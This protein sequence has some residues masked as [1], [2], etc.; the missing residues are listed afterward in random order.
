MIVCEE[1]QKLRKMLEKKELSGM[2]IQKLCLKIKSGLCG[3][4]EHT[5]NI[6]GFN[7]L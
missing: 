1:M 5:L 6:K 3:F 7:F 2:T 4:A